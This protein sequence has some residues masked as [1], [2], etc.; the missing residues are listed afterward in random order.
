M[1]NHYE[2]IGLKYPYRR[3]RVNPIWNAMMTVA[4]EL[5]DS[6]AVPHPYSDDVFMTKDFAVILLKEQPKPPFIQRISSEDSWS[7]NAGWEYHAGNSDRLVKQLEQIGDRFVIGEVTQITKPGDS[8]AIEDY[9]ATIS[10]DENKCPRAELF[11]DSMFQRRMSKYYDLNRMNEHIIIVRDG[12]FGNNR[13]KQRWIAINP[14]LASM[15]GWQPDNSGNFAWKDED[16]HRMVESIYWQNG[17]VNYHGRDTY[18]MGEGWYVLASEEALNQ[19]RELGTLY[20]HQLVERRRE[21]G[22]NAPSSREY[23]VQIV[24]N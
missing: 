22:Y 18:E 3:L 9:S 23:K 10:Y 14:L 21:T 15:L 2:D 19:I 6:G 8:P 17:N 11:G 13:M 20:V 4:S 24:P 1:A 5:L 12:Y 16:G 7:V